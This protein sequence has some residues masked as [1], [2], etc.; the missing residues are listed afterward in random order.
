MAAT[1]L[2]E[3]VARAAAADDLLAQLGLR[4]KQLRDAHER[5]FMA[6]LDHENVKLRAQIAD[7][8]T[9]LIAAEIANGKVHVP[10][11]GE[12][13]SSA[14]PVSTPAPAP[15]KAT[16]VTTAIP[17]PSAA[18]KGTET[19]AGTPAP[20]DAAA[21]KPAKAAKETS[22]KAAPPPVAAAAAIDVSR[23]DLRVG[24]ILKAEQH[25]DADKLYLETIDT[26][27][28]KPRTVISGLA[29]KIPLDQMQGRLVVL[30]MNLKPAKMRGI[31]SEAMVMCA[32]TEGTVEILDPP[33]AAVPGDRVVVPG[34][35]GTPD[36]ELNPKH[37][38]FEEVQPDLKTDAN[39]VATYKGAEW[40]IEGKGT[41]KSQ[42][43]AN[44]GIK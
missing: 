7:V 12:K 6:K 24:R 16:P 9:A 42:T 20:S 23:L 44:A 31:V 32:N 43:L 39:C 26:G 3:Y 15:S 11:P 25:P 28:A 37:K 4:V 1:N 36:A 30:C 5:D 8:K 29:G 27:E 21:P 19:A 35:L 17:T 14:A 33:A 18:T 13:V 22:K 34:F 41:I 2:S 40:I 38:I 10:L